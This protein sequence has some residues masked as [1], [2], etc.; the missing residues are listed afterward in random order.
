MVRH[1]RELAPAIVQ[2]LQDDAARTRMGAAARAYA[3]EDPFS[4]RA[5]ELAAILQR[6][7]CHNRESDR[8]PWIS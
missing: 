8:L 5:A 1:A 2:L 3:E 6:Q 7:T 4:T